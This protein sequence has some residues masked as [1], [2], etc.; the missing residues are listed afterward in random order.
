M[1]ESKLMCHMKREHEGE[2]VVILVSQDWVGHRL[3]SSHLWSGSLSTVLSTVQ[4]MVL[5]YVLCFTLHYTKVQ[6]E[7]CLLK[8]V[9]WRLCMSVRIQFP[10]SHHDSSVTPQSHRFFLSHTDSHSVTH[11]FIDSH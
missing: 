8:A 6:Y 2:L 4:C 7:H 11:V 10:D 3:S 1:G 9:L 5:H